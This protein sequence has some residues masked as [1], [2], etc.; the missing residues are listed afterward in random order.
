VIGLT[1]AEAVQ[2]LDPP[3]PRRELARRLKDVAP[4]GSTYGRRGRRAAV[5][6]IDA[7]MRVHAAWTNGCWRN[8]D[9]HARIPQQEESV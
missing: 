7:I 6:P 5:Y 3:M 9:D 4:C 2:V 1:L 8:R